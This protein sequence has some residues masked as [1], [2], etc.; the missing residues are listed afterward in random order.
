MAVRSNDIGAVVLHLRTPGLVAEFQLQGTEPGLKC[1][2]TDF[3][4]RGE[5]RER[6]ARRNPLQITDSEA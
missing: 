5:L 4:P 1:S 3:V 6:A 2:K